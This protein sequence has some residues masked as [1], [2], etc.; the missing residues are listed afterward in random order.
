[1]KPFSSSSEKE[2]CSPLSSNCVEWQG[3]FLQCINICKGDSVSDIVYKL[4]EKVC[5]ISD[6]SGFNDVNLTCILNSCDNLPAPQN[7]L[8]S[9]LQTIVDGFCC[10]LGTL[11]QTTSLLTSRTANLYNEPTLVLPTNF[12]Y[13]DVDTGLPVAKLPLSDFASNTATNSSILKTTVDTHTLQINNQE[14]RVQSLES[15]P[16]YIPP[17]VTP[18]GN[19]NG[20]ISGIPT[21]MNVLLTAVE[22]DYSVYKLSLGSQ[23][24][25]VNAA[26]AQPPFLGVSEALGQAGTMSGLTG[27]NNS[28]GNLA[29]SVQNLWLTVN[30]VRTAVNTI[31]QNIL[32][33]CSQFILGFTSAA[34][35]SRT[36]I[37][38]TFN[39]LT[40]IPSGFSNCPK[41]SFVTITDG[42]NTYSDTFDL[43]L[44]ATNPAGIDF[45]ITSAGLNASLPY[46]ITVD[47]C[48][49]NGG[50]TC[51][52][53]V[54]NINSPVST[55]TTVAPF[56]QYLLTLVQGDIDL[57]INNTDAFF[58]GK[59]WVT[60]V[61]YTN[62]IIVQSYTAPTGITVCTAA[63]SVPIVYVYK[64]DLVLEGESTIVYLTTC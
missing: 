56:K 55:T 20:V 17:T 49:I 38:L 64:N 11:N 1:M 9:I 63:S 45:N 51:S 54:V 27:W 8:S 41:L 2:N 39:A 28:I 32:P 22:N 40:T 16:G 14:L 34:D 31:K 23:T 12:Q 35:V 53:S 26:T 15:N 50:T 3:P 62:T 37:T 10:S 7:T 21:Q 57:A 60:Y 5:N 44:V 4:S 59:V 18:S 19:Y 6:S 46:T 24:D 36:T 43:V 42:L 33:D 13:I 25:L 29:Q 47:G 52:K 61:D 48:I 58:D 30:D